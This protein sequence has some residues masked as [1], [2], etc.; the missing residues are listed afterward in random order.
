M[1][2]YPTN[3]TLQTQKRARRGDAIVRYA[4]LRAGQAIPVSDCLVGVDDDGFVLPA[5]EFATV[6]AFMAVYAGVCPDNVD[7]DANVDRVVAIIVGGTH[8]AFDCDAADIP[9]GRE[10]SPVL[11]AGFVSNRKVVASAVDGVSIIGAA[12]A[13]SVNPATWMQEAGATSVEVAIWS[14]R[15]I[16]GW[17]PA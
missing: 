13:P 17:Y 6:A 3:P 5:G 1:Y 12:A 16:G 7:A 9:A 15:M 11:V 8:I 14:D 2:T 4:V 10:I